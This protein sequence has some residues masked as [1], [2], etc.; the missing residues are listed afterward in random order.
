L[1][2]GSLGA[3][4]MKTG[5]R[6]TKPSSRFVPLRDLAPRNDPKG[7][8]AQKGSR[9]NIDGAAAVDG[10]GGHITYLRVIRSLATPKTSRKGDAGDGTTVV[11]DASG[12]ELA[13]SV[14]QVEIE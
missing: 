14:F 10:F 6:R 1:P 12:K 7:G 4:V 11:S 9:R 13:L 2:E 8:A 3:S 5:R